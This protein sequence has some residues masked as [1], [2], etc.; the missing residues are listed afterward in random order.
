MQGTREIK[1]RIK[2]TTK[3]RQ[4][5]K[6]MKMVSA[7]KFK[8]AHSAILSSR[9]YANKL[10]ELMAEI[11]NRSSHTHPL[12]YSKQA[13]NILIVVITSDKG[14]CSSFNSNL[15]K[16]TVGYITKKEIIKENSEINL[17][18]IGKKGKDGL[19]KH[20]QKIKNIYIDVFKNLT[21]SSAEKI[22]QELIDHYLK[23]EY[24]EIYVLY[25]EFKTAM[26]SKI[27]LE[28][29]LPIFPQAKDNWHRKSKTDYLYEPNS[30]DIMNELVPKYVKFQFY[31]ILLESNAS[32]Q[33]QRMTIM[34]K[35]TKNADEMLT[36]LTLAF[37]KARQ[38]TITREIADLVGGA[39]ALK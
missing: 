1:R 12:L 30:D 18:V 10:K 27:V 17:F 6:A 24:G 7:I 26:Q 11:S 29:L 5:T 3:I 32:E 8:H 25:N 33:G 23:S 39:E 31:R 35:A 13:N 16:K 4:I 37:N 22:A 14:L 15:L 34:D 36:D 2:S 20:T 28:K 38:S 19:K 9:P 21:Y